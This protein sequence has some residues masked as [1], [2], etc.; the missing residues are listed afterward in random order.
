[1]KLGV[2]GKLFGISLGLIV[3]GALISGVFVETV[4]RR[5]LVDQVRQ[6][7]ERLANLSVHALETDR[8]PMAVGSHQTLVKSLGSK[9]RARVTIVGRDGVVLADSDVAAAELKAIENH[10]TRPEIRA[11]ARDGSGVASRYS[12]TV[13]KEMMY[14]AMPFRRADASGFVRVALSLS[15]VEA[16]IAN[17]RGLISGAVLLGL[18]VA[19]LMGGLASYFASR[20]LVDLVTRARV[21]ASGAR[22][23]RIEAEGEDELKGLAGSFNRMADEL[24]R[25]I[26]TLGTE[27]DRMQAI[28]ES[29]TDAVLAI[30]ARA[31]ISE[32][33][34]S[35]R[36]LLQ[37]E[38]THVGAPLIDVIRAPEINEIVRRAQSGETATTEFVWPGPSRRLLTATATPQRG[39]GQLVLVLRDVTDLR[40]LETMRRD[41]VANVSHELRTP[42]SI[43]RA[44]VETLAAGALNDPARAGEFLAAVH[45]NAER[46][47]RL[48]SDLLDLSRIEAGSQEFELKP[49]T[50]DVPVGGVFELMETR[51]LDKNIQFEVDVADDLE[52]VADARGLEHVLVNL[53]DNAV[54]YTP[55][56]GTVGLEVKRATGGVLFE[57]WDTGPGV[58]ESHR[59]RLF[60]RFYRVDPGRSRD[61]G[62]T[63]L[64]LAIVKHLV[65][66]MGGQVGMRPRPGGGSVF[67]ALFPSA[68]EV[69]R[70]SVPPAV[71]I[72]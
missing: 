22:G 55:A 3:L 67:W 45:R 51:A 25:T 70:P 65:E 2:R 10:G 64:G 59:A 71:R 32:A 37:L 21:V 4:M 14:L 31:C 53:V 52:L 33:N 27:R 69:P 41:F 44:N 11:A 35:A 49:L 47:S 24:D 8:A 38:A 9:A 17:M 57:V 23:E 60:E 1:L 20:S 19:G 28:L 63:G 26:E 34:R 56:G 58:P 16:L 5:L 61:M 62:G 48:V 40:R 13:R 30:D 66:A 68:D 15:D 12:S 42:V 18:M 36:K 7:L 72:G 39:R 29:L 43:I 46:L 54:K 6:E 50:P